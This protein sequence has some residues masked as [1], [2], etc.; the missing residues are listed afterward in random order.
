LISKFLS[1]LLIEQVIPNPA[2]VASIAI[3]AITA[4]ISTKVKP[5]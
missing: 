5:L 3:I 4:I 1:L 2:A